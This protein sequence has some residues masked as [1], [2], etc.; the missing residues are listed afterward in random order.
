MDEESLL[1]GVL[2]SPGDASGWLVLADWLEE[3]GDARAELVRL[4][5]DPN[6]RRGL[7]GAKRDARVRE[8]LISGVKPCVPEL[9]NSIGMRLVLIPAGTFRMGSPPGEAE[10]ESPEGPQHEVEI[11]RPFLLGACLVTQ[12]EY[13]KVMGHNPSW[14][15][16]G[17][18]VKDDVKGMDTGPFPI[19]HVT[20]EDAAQF[21]RKL[22]A[23][24]KE[25]KAGRAYRLPTEAEWEY[26]CRGG[27]K[28]HTAF[29]FGPSLSSTQANFDGRE[30][31][32]GAPR[33]PYLG[34]PTEV[35]SYPPNAWGL[36]DMHGN[37][38]EWCSDWWSGGGKKGPLQDP[39]GPEKGEF[40]V[41]RGGCF[42]N[43]GHYCRTASR[44]GLVPNDPTHN[45]GFR[46][47]CDV[48]RKG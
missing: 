43:A 20:W 36:Y 6:F 30:P 32:G 11:S 37:V 31:Y 9:V 35:G 1:R 18:I 24:P 46:V 4:L 17:G 13:G 47:A 41:M 10:R 15:S 22:S 14:Y 38:W 44:H 42:H 26:A 48:E 23:R 3:Q 34:R 5:H 19:S 25:K 27:A 45:I 12:E 28:S 29:S 7:K 2:D 21:C 39:K 40:R 16:A 33:G 8:L